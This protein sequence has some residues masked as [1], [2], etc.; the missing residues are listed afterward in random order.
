MLILGLFC[1]FR[2][3]NWFQVFWLAILCLVNYW[4]LGS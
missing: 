1:T 3:N 4:R 2:S